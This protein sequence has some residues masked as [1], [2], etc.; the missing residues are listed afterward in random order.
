[1]ANAPLARLLAERFTVFN[2]DRRGR[3]DSDDTAPY[4]VEHGV[5]DIGAVIDVAGESAF[6]YGTFP[7]AAPALEAAVSG[8]A[9]RKLALWEPP[10]ILDESR[11]QPADLVERYDEMISAGRRGNAVEYFMT[12]VVGLP[13]EF[14][15][16]A[17]TQPIW[18]AQE[19]LV[20]TLAYDATVIGDYLLP[21]EQAAAFTIPT[22]VMA[23]GASFPFIRETAR[24]LADIF[25]YGQHR[26]L[27]GQEENVDPAVLAP[28]LLNFFKIQD[29][30]L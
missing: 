16:S 7:G 26:T 9:V 14:V 24:V 20:H 28:V 1:M 19:A 18:Q 5:E 2:Y 29:G 27:E 12:K 11:R 10:F 25:P 13:P 17:Q 30:T 4:V 3:G 23:G 22:L 21:V 15:A 6:L 8:L